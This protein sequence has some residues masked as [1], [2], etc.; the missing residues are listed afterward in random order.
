M[1]KHDITQVCT[2]AAHLATKHAL[3]FTFDTN[4]GELTHESWAVRAAADAMKLQRLGR[5]TRNLFKKLEGVWA[6]RL[7]LG[8]LEKGR[9]EEAGNTLLNPYGLSCH[10]SGEYPGFYIKGLPA[11]TESAIEE[12]LL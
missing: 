12:F 1:S 2:L 8:V 6:F 10:V 3:N 9:I 4:S 7:E 11:N 5:R